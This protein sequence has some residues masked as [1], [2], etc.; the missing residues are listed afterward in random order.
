MTH[1]RT[2]A[3]GALALVLFRA[4][5]WVSGH[6]AADL[7]VDS[8]PSIQDAIDAADDGD[9]IRVPAGYFTA[10]LALETSS[11]RPRPRVCP[12]RSCTTPTPPRRG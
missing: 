12:G 10:T 7:S 4:F 3:A 2:A 9:L 11:S 5:L 6:S 8:Y 1:R